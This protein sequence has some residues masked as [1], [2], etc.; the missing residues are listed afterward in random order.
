MS[1]KYVLS[2]FGLHNPYIVAATP[3]HAVYPVGVEGDD[4]V[5]LDYSLLLVGTG[6][7]FDASALDFL[8]DEQRRLPFLAPLVSTVLRLKSEGLLETF[9]GD[10]LVAEN[11]SQ[12]I[13]KTELLCEDISGWLG[14]VRAQWSVLK[15]DRAAFLQRFGTP[16]RR[17]INEQHFAVA[18]AVVR[19]SGSLDPVLLREITR[20]ID[21]RRK[22]FTSVE[23]TYVKEVLRPLVCHTVIQDLVRFKTGGA[24]LDWDD[25]QP[26][27]ERLYA[28]RWE[29]DDE[30]LLANGAK[31]LFAFSLPE[32]R[33]KSVDAVIRFVRN[34]RAVRG[35]RE[36]IAAVLARGDK[37]DVELGKRIV[38]EV[39]ESEL[40]NKRR[41]KR[42]RFLGAAASLFVPGGSLLTEAAVE[43]AG[44]VVEDATESVLQRP[45]RWFYSLRG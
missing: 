11:R 16:E 22:T 39:L 8:R 2:S 44:H 28:A 45:H 31:G 29:R 30:R 41:M 25:S 42:F 35:L 34:N 6:F 13:A 1:I 4:F 33:P 24:I 43:G 36:D 40:A 26:Y 5:D 17:E 27:Y 20:L 37:F 9:D 32:L 21:S 38:A 23:L 15:E 18:N 3:D 10:R 7:L 19:I 12:I 14:P